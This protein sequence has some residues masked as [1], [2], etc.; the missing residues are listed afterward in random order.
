LLDKEFYAA[1]V[2]DLLQRADVAFL[3]PAEKKPSCAHL[4]DPQTA[5]GW[6]EYGWTG[7]LMRYDPKVKK[8]RKKGEL[9]VRVRACVARH[10]KTGEPLVY[11]TWGLVGWSPVQVAEEYRR[12]FGIETSYRQLNECLARTSSRNERYRLLLV[13][14]ALLLCNLWAY[15]HCEVFSTGKLCETRLQLWRMRL[16]HLRV[17]MAT[18]IAALFGGCVTE[19]QTQRP[20]PP[21]FMH[22]S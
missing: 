20:V 12:R 16:L 13:G 1:E 21:D 15:L 11:A 2:I 17:A 4:Y 7:A 6:Y 10:R 18:V 19:F 8:R 22:E 14:M 9:A 3:M 5:V